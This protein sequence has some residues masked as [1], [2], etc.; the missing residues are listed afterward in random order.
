LPL[1]MYTPLIYGKSFSF[2]EEWIRPTC[3]HGIASSCCILNK[4]KTIT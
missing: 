2:V 3:Y 1:T 4:L